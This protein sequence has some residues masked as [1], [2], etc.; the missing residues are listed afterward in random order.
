MDILAQIVADKR[1]EVM[2]KQQAIPLN[3]LINQ[4]AGLKPGRSLAAALRH[5]KTGIIAEFKRKSPSKGFI[6]QEADVTSIV[7]SYEQAG[8]SGIS[9]LTDF[10]YFGGLINDLKTARKV[11]DCPLLRKD[12]MVDPYQLYEAKLLGADVVLLIAACLSLDEAYDLGELAHELG[13]EVLL[14]VHSEEELNYISRFTDLVGVNNRQ[15]K[16]FVTE[17][18]TSFDLVS[19]IPD[20]Y[21][22]VSESGLDD[23]DVVKDLK[24]AG[25]SGF[26]MGERFIKFPD[27]GAELASFINR[28]NQ[29]I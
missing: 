6:H 29:S 24:K 3:Y 26:L 27:P 15:L 12:F 21:I 11:V 16:T 8:C 19:K 5:S 4:T 17:V 25:Y 2:A 10:P 18:R 13:M 14:E 1:Q 7:R 20:Q 22:K 28:L 23:P 9:V